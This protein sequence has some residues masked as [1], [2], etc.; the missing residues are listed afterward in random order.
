M[1]VLF[2]GTFRPGT[3]HSSPAPTSHS[4]TG[5][6]KDWQWQSAGLLSCSILTLSL[7]GY[8]PLSLLPN[9]MEK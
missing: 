5:L 3:F 6:E 7:L 2:A 9:E 1:G 8:H 4:P